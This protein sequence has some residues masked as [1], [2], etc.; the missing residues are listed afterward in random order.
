MMSTDLLVLKG[1][2]VGGARKRARLK[3]IDLTIQEGERVAL[4]GRSGAGKSTLLAV[5]NGS[6]QPDQGWAYWR[7]ILLAKRKPRQRQAIATL[8]QDLRLVEGLNV[9]QNINAGALSQRNLLWALANL[10]SCIETDDCKKCLE[11]SGLPGDLL[12]A[13]IAK[14]SGGQRQRVA[15]AR[16]VR[17]GAELILADEPLSSLDPTLAADVL[18]LLLGSKDFKGLNIASTVLVSLHRPDLIHRFD[19]VLGLRAGKLVVDEPAENLDPKGL[20]WLYQAE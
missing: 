6:L 2:W 15:L 9:C 11:A 16:L 1:I 5:A 3:D 17:Q 20:D 8:W 19:R 14:L 18:Q 12:G 10:L 13:S 4:L 7:G